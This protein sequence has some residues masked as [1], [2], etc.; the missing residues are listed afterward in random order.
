MEKNNQIVD[1]MKQSRGRFFGLN[2]KQGETLNA[3][4]VK[5]TPYYVVVRDRNSQ[6]VRKFAKRSLKNI[7]IKGE[8]V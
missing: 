2:T 4:F 7:S 8:T 6:R 3:Q 5:E 1:I